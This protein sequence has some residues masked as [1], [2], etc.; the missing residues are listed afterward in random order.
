MDGDLIKSKTYEV[1]IVH[2]LALY[3]E[4]FVQTLGKGYS[5]DIEYNRN[6]DGPKRIFKEGN[7]S[8]P[9][10]IIH[11]RKTNDYNLLVLE[12]KTSWSQISNEEDRKKVE[13]FCDK[14]G[15]FRFKYGVLLYLGKD[16]KH[17][18]IE[19]VD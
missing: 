7:G 11:K 13:L 5:C 19:F 2:R 3:L 10:L 14:D 18:E 8:R 1:S 9:D 12:C 6:Y 17:V 15:E 4:P 16:E